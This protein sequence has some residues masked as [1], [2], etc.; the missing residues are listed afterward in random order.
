MVG[1]KFVLYQLLLRA[2]GNRDC[3]SG[4]SYAVNGSGKFNEITATYLRKLHK[5]SVGAV[6]YTGIISH[7]TR[8]S[9]NGVP[10][11]NP[12]LVKGEAGSP[13][14]IRNYFDVDPALAV[15]PD[16]R[17]TE[18]M[19]LVSRT[20]SAGM[21]VIIDFVPN[22]VAREYGGYFTS[23]NYY[24]LDAPL[25]LPC[26]DGGYVENPA[27]ATGNN[28]FNPAPSANDWYDTVKLNYDNRSTWV[29][30][31]DILRF[32]LEKGV[33]GFRCDMVEMVPLDFFRWVIA[34]VRNLYPDMLFIAEV[35]SRENYFPYIR[36]AGFDLLYDK[37]GI[38]DILR[39]VMTSGTPASDITGNWLSLGD[40]QPHMLNFLEN[41]DEQRLASPFFAG[42][43]MHGL[44][45]L[46]AAALL[47]DASFMLY[48]GQE[49]GEDASESQNGRTSIFDLTAVPGLCGLDSFIHTGKGLGKSGRSVL[50]RYRE[51]LHLAAS[52]LFRKGKMFDLGYCS[53]FDRREI[54][55]F[56]RGNGRK[57]CLVVANF[58][59]R[60][61][62]VTV[63]IPPEA[64]A[65]LEMKNASPESGVKVSIPPFGATVKEI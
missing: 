48:A 36:E 29:K 41:H 64:V 49:V 45:A 2:F 44:A 40:L 10:S 59:N 51:I 37:S 47:N 11:S 54:F 46:A 22:H 15:N 33:D 1:E 63:V 14:A 19:N 23:E 30:M 42:D 20:H 61:Q 16:N 28:V 27:K 39:S 6:W 9:F 56:A 21:K 62:E 58:S 32:W 4:G 17:M 26:D 38:Y 57:T 13:Y 8:T 5:L 25:Q 3:I 52:P 50:A 7:A 18:F 24:L 60:I 55:A 43:A 35:Y 34:E 12:S 65:Y 31:L 53:G